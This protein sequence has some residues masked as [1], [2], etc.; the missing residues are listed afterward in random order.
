MDHNS[1]LN[2]FVKEILSSFHLESHFVYNAVW[3]D[4]YV[5]LK[6]LFLKLVFFYD[7]W[8]GQLLSSSARYTSW[9][10]F[11]LHKLADEEPRSTVKWEPVQRSKVDEHEAVIL[12]FSGHKV[13]LE[14]LFKWTIILNLK[15]CSRVK[16]KNSQTQQIGWVSKLVSFNS[17]LGSIC[18]ES[19]SNPNLVCVFYG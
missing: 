14:M 16:W 9:V 8:Q 15:T 17:I 7:E 13:C 2:T 6:S 5:D 19:N 3:T 4:S 12:Y 10:A 1:I 18:M 11:E